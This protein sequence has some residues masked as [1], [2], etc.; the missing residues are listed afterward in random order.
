MDGAEDA[1]DL[2]ALDASEAERETG[3]QPVPWEQVKI[4]LGL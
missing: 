3:A 2:A 4:E 1:T